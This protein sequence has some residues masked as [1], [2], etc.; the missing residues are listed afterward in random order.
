MRILQYNSVRESA[1]DGSLRL[2]QVVKTKNVL[3]Q[4]SIKGLKTGLKHIVTPFF[5]NVGAVIS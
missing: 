5:F 3:H 2:S 1:R 4:K